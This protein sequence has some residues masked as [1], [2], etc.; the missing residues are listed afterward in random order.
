MLNRLLKILNP[1]AYKKDD[2]S[3]PLSLLQKGDTVYLLFVRN[4]EI[5]YT[6]DLYDATEA[7]NL[8]T[9]KATVYGIDRNKDFNDLLQLTPIY[10]DD[11]NS[12][13]VLGGHGVVAPLICF[14]TKNINK[15]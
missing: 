14:S 15:L 5:R 3:K 6:F 12:C 10:E 1:S 13:R 4:K 11:E 8:W 2:I 7:K 9:L